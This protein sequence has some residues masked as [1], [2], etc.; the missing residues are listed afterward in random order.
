MW[1]LGEESDIS[2]FRLLIVPCGSRNEVCIFIWGPLLAPRG[3]LHSLF[4]GLLSLQANDGELIRR[5]LFM[6]QISQLLCLTSRS[7]CKGLLCL[8]QVYLDN[9]YFKVI[10]YGTL[11]TLSDFLPSSSTY[12][13]VWWSNWE[14]VCG[15]HGP[16]ILR[17]LSPTHPSAFVCFE[18]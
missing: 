5:I 18:A 12:T 14:K 6:F 13:V 9:S 11:L 17:G 4:H 15:Y 10:W 7:R 1:R 2:T 16:G 3:C 8:G